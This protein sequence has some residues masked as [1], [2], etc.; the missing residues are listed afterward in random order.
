MMAK[1]VLKRVRFT[2]EVLCH[3]DVN[4]EEMDLATVLR[5]C[6]TGDMSGNSLGHEV[7]LLTLQQAVKACAEH[8]SDAE[9]FDLA[10][11]EDGQRVWWTDPDRGL[12]SGWWTIV[13]YDGGGI[14]N[15]TNKAG[16]ECQACNHELSLKK[17][18]K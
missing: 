15:M 8:G 1:F 11:F 2:Y 4:C 10:E 18:K 3:I 9:F 5:E 14:Y 13:G 12:S 16:G 6:V 17:P 7:K